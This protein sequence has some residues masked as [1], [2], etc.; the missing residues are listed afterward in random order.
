MRVLHADRTVGVYKRRVVARRGVCRRRH[1]TSARR[2]LMAWTRRSEVAWGRRRFDECTDSVS[3]A[4]WGRLVPECVNNRT[5]PYR[6]RS[7]AVV[8]HCH[9]RGVDGKP[10][11]RWG[12]RWGACL[13]GRYATRRRPAWEGDGA[14][15]LVSSGLFGVR[16]AGSCP[17][18]H[19]Q[20]NCL[21]PGGAVATPCT[22]ELRSE[23]ESVDCQVP[24]RRKCLPIRGGAA[25][26]ERR[27]A[28]RLCTLA[29]G[30][31]LEQPI[32]RH[33]RHFIAERLARSEPSISLHLGVCGAFRATPG[34]ASSIRGI[35][36]RESFRFGTLGG[37]ARAAPGRSVRAGGAG[38]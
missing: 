13:Q 11:S 30:Q 9:E 22:S 24:S 16:A 26:P 4:H 36:E 14:L 23:R 25:G 31:R 38:S 12:R 35:A 15:P 6:F 32:A 18:V 5:F 20:K 28:P 34:T 27:L 29:L 17:R 2:C 7:V 3:S 8:T 19:R 37:A 21:E 33:F 1:G 10:G